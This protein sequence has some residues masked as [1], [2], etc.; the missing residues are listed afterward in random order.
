MAV[1]EQTFLSGNQNLG[2]TAVAVM[3]KILQIE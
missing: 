1:D 2:Y 3:A